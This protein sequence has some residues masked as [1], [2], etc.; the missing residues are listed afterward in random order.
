MTVLHSGTTK[1]YSEQW[2]AIFGD[3]KPKKKVTANKKKAAPK[4]KKAKKKT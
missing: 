2:G 3:A 4:K 1:K